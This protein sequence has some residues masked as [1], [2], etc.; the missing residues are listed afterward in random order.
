[1]PCCIYY[2]TLYLLSDSTFFYESLSNSATDTHI[3]SIANT[4]H[5]LHD[6]NYNKFLSDDL[7]DVKVLHCVTENG[8]VFQT[9]HVLGTEDQS[10]HVV[11]KGNPGR[12]LL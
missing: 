8:K 12:K 2:E 7:N 10:L 1:M 11:V 5:T 3:A 6:H 9:E 4:W